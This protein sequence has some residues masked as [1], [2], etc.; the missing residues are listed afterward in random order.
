MMLTTAMTSKSP[1]AP[2]SDDATVTSVAGGNAEPD[3]VN[4]FQIA[5]DFIAA[6]G[7]LALSTWGNDGTLELLD[8]VRSE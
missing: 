1:F 6:E 3:V 8:C 5:N 2:F 4:N 7:E